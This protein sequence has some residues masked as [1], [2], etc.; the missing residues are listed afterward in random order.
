MINILLLVCCEEFFFDGS[1][2]TRIWL[3]NT[4]YWEWNADFHDDHD[5]RCSAFYRIIL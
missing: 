5:F 1:R 3:M 2:M 4:D